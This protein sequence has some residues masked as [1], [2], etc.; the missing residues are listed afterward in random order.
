MPSFLE[1]NIKIQKSTETLP[2]PSNEY[3]NTICIKKGGRRSTEKCKY[4][5][6]NITQLIMSGFGNLVD[7]SKLLED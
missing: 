3:R 6:K 4:K 7:V 2:S 1:R 5:N